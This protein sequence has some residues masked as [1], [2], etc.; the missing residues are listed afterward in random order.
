ME[1]FIDTHA[2]LDYDLFDEDREIVIQ[3]AIKNGVGAIITIGVDLESSQ[4]AIDIAEKY[5]MVFAAVGIHP[6]ECANV[7][8]SEFD[9]IE[10]LARHEKVVAIGEVGLDY[11]HMRAPKD[12]QKNA[13]L[14][15]AHLAQ[16]LGLPLIIHNRDSHDDMYELITTKNI[17]EIGGV[18]HSF[19][20]S[21]EFLEKILLTD[22]YISFTG[23]VTFKN[24]KLDTLVER[25]PLERLLLE[26]DSPFLTPVP[27]RGKRNEP[28]FII[29]TAQKIAEIKQISV[30]DLGKITT[31]NAKRLFKKLDI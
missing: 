5:A 27:L 10:E 19:S 11:Y 1:L 31:E 3:R 8:D 25:V 22:L 30:E 7:P 21:I 28:A 29:Y 2:H 9:R 12:V 17:S 24:S 14:Y 16:K 20:G 6:T 13:F 15:Q 23:N 26:T 18:M 4:K